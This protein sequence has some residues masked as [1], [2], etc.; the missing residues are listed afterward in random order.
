MRGKLRHGLEATL[1]PQ[2]P[3]GASISLPGPFLR[4]FRSRRSRPFSFPALEVSLFAQ[5]PEGEIPSP[6]ICCC[7]IFMRLDVTAATG[8]GRH[9]GRSLLGGNIKI[10]GAGDGILGCPDPAP[11]PPSPALP[12]GAALPTPKMGILCSQFLNCA[13]GEAFFGI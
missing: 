5:N 1:G 2:E 10:L 4:S 3:P 6:Q 11:F 13:S 8:H 12:L 7:S 9:H